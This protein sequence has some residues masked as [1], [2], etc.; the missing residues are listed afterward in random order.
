MIRLIVLAYLVRLGFMVGMTY[1][2][3]YFITAKIIAPIFLA[4]AASFAPLGF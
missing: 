1:L 4:I 2:V 3:V